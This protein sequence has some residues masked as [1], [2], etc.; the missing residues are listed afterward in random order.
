MRA[1]T[2]GP[3]QENQRHHDDELRRRAAQIDAELSQARERLHEAQRAV[4]NAGQ[5]L[6]IARIERHVAALEVAELAERLERLQSQLESADD[7]P[8]ALVL[9][10]TVGMIPPTDTHAR[11]AG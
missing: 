1:R 2:N 10:A 8:V 7:A 9:P 5:V 4:H 6:A 3:L 11:V